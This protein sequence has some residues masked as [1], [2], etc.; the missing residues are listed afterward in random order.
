MAIRRESCTRREWVAQVSLLR[1]GFLFAN[2]FSPRLART[3][4]Q[5]NPGLKSETWATHST[6]VRSAN[7]IFLDGPKAH[8]H[9]GWDDFHESAAV[10]NGRKKQFARI[11]MALA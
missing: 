3:L 5:R 4:V 2:E 6:F 1:P 10:G 8:E 7:F 11:A 9:S